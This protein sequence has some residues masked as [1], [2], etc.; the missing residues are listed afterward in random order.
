MTVYYDSWETTN[1]KIKEDL[2]KGRTHAFASD[3]LLP[4]ELQ[5][6]KWW[7]SDDTVL[8]K[9]IKEK[10]IKYDPTTLNKLFLLLFFLFIAFIFLSEGL[11]RING[12]EK[13]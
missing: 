12:N 5:Y 11:F 9:A 13:S 2:M 3:S 6:G 4:E 10:K 8:R 7:R 1:I